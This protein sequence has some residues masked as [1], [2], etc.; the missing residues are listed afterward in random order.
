MDQWSL[1]KEAAARRAVEEVKGGMLVGL[2]TGSTANYAIRAL[3]EMSA[4]GLKFRAVASSIA[5]ANLAS[6]L[7][8]EV[9]SELRTPRL[10][11]VI[12]GADEV[13]PAFRA[14]KGGGGALFREKI[15]AAAADRVII[16]VDSSKTV[17]VLGRFKLPMEVLPF[18]VA[19]VLGALREM[20]IEATQRLV[21]G[22][23][24]LTDQNNFILDAAIQTIRE[25]EALALALEQ[26]P[27]ILEHGLFLTEVDEVMIG[28][29]DQVEIRRRAAAA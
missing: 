10:D 22:A 27:G 18:A 19:F 28:R 12:D 25:P 13:D 21:D 16:V 7:G 2:G 15:L 11:L 20:G 3:A 26:I 6:S 23:P 29:G 24:F 1:E 9:M 4:N 5:S 14:I 17:D 8:L